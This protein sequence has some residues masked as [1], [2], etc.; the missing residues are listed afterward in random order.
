MK[1]DYGP[2]KAVADSLI[3]QFGKPAT[4]IQTMQSGP[5]FD[6]V[7]TETQ[8]AIVLVESGYSLTNRNE[9]LVQAGDKLW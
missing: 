6:P 9:S 4:L 7:I 8:T 5:E 3:D 2:I 1:F